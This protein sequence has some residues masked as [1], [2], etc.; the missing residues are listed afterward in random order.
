MS[1]EENRSFLKGE[2]MARIECP[3]CKSL[4]VKEVE[5]KSKVI[6]YFNHVPVYKKKIVC[7]DCTYEW[8][9]DEKE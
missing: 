9:P 2:K 6:A 3:K 7:K 8:Y 1:Q 5:D 4:N